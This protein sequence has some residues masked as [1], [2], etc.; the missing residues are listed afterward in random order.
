MTQATKPT[1]SGADAADYVF[2]RWHDWYGTVG[3]EYHPPYLVVTRAAHDWRLLVPVTDADA[4]LIEGADAGVRALP[5]DLRA[6]AA[7]PDNR[8]REVYRALGNASGGIYPV[9]T[10]GGWSVGINFL[11]DGD[12]LRLEVGASSDRFE[13][14]TGH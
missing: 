3:V 7:V 13:T 11:D 10:A 6:D 12:R 8:E 4:H 9:D 14:V 1:H 5:A 2:G